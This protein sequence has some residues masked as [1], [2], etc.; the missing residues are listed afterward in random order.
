MESGG[1]IVLNGPSSAGKTTLAAAAVARLGP[2]GAA[3]SI[4][5][6]FGFV[7]PDAGTGWGVF[8][9]LTESI[10][11]AAAALARH[12]FQVFVDTVFERVECF[13]IATRLLNRLPHRFVAVSCSLELLEARELARG[14]RG[15]GQARRQHASVIGNAAHD[16]VLDTGV[17]SV[18]DCCDAVLALLPAQRQT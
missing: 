3:V 4:D 1:I 16:L 2:T 17:S 14:D 8:A 12:G 6:F 10:F 15:L 13:E 9:A 5:D 18:A 7:S 11:A